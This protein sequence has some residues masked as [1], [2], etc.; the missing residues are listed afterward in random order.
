MKKLPLYSILV[1]LIVV[2]A[3]GY[4]KNG[5]RDFDSSKITG[6]LGE[7]WK[8]FL[9]FFSNKE[10]PI[11]TNSYLDIIT[12]SSIGQAFQENLGANANL[13]FWTLVGLIVLSLLIIVFN[14]FTKK[15]I[16]TSLPV[17]GI[18]VLLVLIF[19]SFFETGDTDKSDSQTEVAI[20]V[21]PGTKKGQF[22]VVPMMKSTI[23][24]VHIPTAYR[25]EVGNKVFWACPE[26]I[27]P[28][29]LFDLVMFEVVAGK[30]TNINSIQIVQESRENLFDQGIEIITVKFTLFLSEIN[31]CLYLK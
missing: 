13:V 15:S 28:K 27:K 31:P 20:E 17:L 23:A 16:S 5:N 14:F 25:K 9:N 19:I 30:Y 24:K 6:S 11:E 21:R 10:T 18:V 26:V 4:F 3:F 7:M 12:S 8:E 22:A 1:I 2:S 29:K